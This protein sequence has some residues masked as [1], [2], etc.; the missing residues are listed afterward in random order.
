MPYDA[1]VEITA[2][3]AASVVAADAADAT[4]NDNDDLAAAAESEESSKADATV[5]PANSNG[6]DLDSND[7]STATTT[8]KSTLDKGAIV[9]VSMATVAASVNGY[10]S[11]TPSTT[12]D[13]ETK[14][15]GVNGIDDAVNGINGV[16]NHNEETVNGMADSVNG[17]KSTDHND[18]TSKE[19]VFF[20]DATQQQQQSDNDDEAKIN[21]GDAT[22]VEEGPWT[23]RDEPYP[24]E[25]LGVEP[26]ATM[27]E[28]K[29][30]YRKKAMEL[31]LDSSNTDDSEEVAEKL[32][33]VVEAFQVLSGGYKKG[34][35]EQE[36]QMLQRLQRRKEKE[37]VVETDGDETS[38]LASLEDLLPAMLYEQ[39]SLRFNS[40]EPS[41][42]PLQK[43]C[44]KAIVEGED[45]VLNAPAESGKT[46]GY[47]LPLLARLPDTRNVSEAEAAA[48]EILNVNNKRG[49]RRKRNRRNKL[50]AEV[51][52]LSQPCKPTLLFVAPSK[53]VALGIGKLCSQYH[54]DKDGAVATVFEGVPVKKQ[55]NLLQK[56]SLEIVVGTPSRLL[57]YILMGV[58]D[59][60]GVKT[61]VVDEAAGMLDHLGVIEDLF[62][63][64]PSDD[65]QKVVTSVEMPSELLEFCEENM[66]LIPESSNF[67]TLPEEKEEVTAETLVESQEEEIDEEEIEDETSDEAEMDIEDAIENDLDD[68][69]ITVEF[70]DVRASEVPV[71]LNTA[72]LAAM[73]HWHTATRPTDRP[74]LSLDIIASMSPVPKVVVLFVPSDED[75]ESVATE[76][77]MFHNTLV[78]TLAD[79]SSDDYRTE[80]LDSIR[81]H[82]ES[83][84]SES[85]ILVISDAAASKAHLPPADLIL[86]YGIPRQPRNPNLYDANVYMTRVQR[87][88][89]NNKDTQAMLL[90]DYEEEGR[91]LPGLQ[92]EME[93]DSDIVLKPRALPSPQ[94]TLEASYLRTKSYCDSLDCIPMVVESFE[95]QLKEELTGM[96]DMDREDELFHRLAVAMAALSNPSKLTEESP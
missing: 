42:L 54:D 87:A 67:I 81:A 25:V 31:S 6:D 10:A 37:Q 33:Q 9:E 28:I 56:A 34:K 82:T 26:G 96:D 49:Q 72:V 8:A 90:Y 36:Y 45:V 68:E 24:F 63:S 43:E 74:I 92:T 20:F 7:K 66:G 44:Y 47:V 60:A 79:G 27:S 55:K 30:A 11:P 5:F 59:P 86:Q 94:H 16:V 17:S 3:G 19:E 38:D 88:C 91:L 2:D 76:L 83:G 61:I 35:Y 29:A 65:Y 77:E 80:T 93:V 58:L 18:D 15:G 64:I 70:E 51:Q 62:V 40:T 75:A 48:E 89:G 84:A 95:K 21:G 53:D 4:T 46:L 39:V 50:A 71:E 32:R 41:L 12:T 69:I 52:E 13:D 78:K 57:K 73:D 22:A 85:M 1:A 14:E 23:T